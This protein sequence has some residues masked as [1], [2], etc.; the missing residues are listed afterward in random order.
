MATLN[1]H[2]ILKKNE[3][4]RLLSG[5]QW[6]FSNELHRIEGNPVSGDVVEILR[7]NGESLGIGFYNPNSLIAIRFLSSKVEE[8]NTEF[9]TKRISS[10]LAIRMKLFPTRD[11]FRVVHSESDFLPGLIIDKYGDFLS[12]QTNSTG[13]DI[14]LDIICEALKNIFS[15]KG[16]IERNES[17]LR[18]LENL[19]LRK[20]ILFGTAELTTVELNGVKFQIDILGGQKSGFY[21]DQ[22]ENRISLQTFAKDATVL[23]CF[24]NEGGFGLYAAM[25]GAKKVTG[26]DIS[27]DAVNRATAN[28]ALNGLKNIEF[29]TDDVF[30][31]LKKAVA[32]KL[33]YDIVI[34]D[35]PSFTK[36]KK[37]VS[38]AIRGYKEINTNGLQLVQSGGIFIS[39]SCSHHI[40]QNTFLDVLN[41]SAIK[42][43]K[44]IRLLKFSG[45]S[46][47]HP[48]LPSMP[49]TQY[50]KFALFNVD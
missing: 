10:A 4:R 17:Q 35:P 24:C 3:E 23:D 36:N 29:Q 7:G 42:A 38:A 21:L 28:A 37:T 44:K 26:V 22:R 33:R 6:I 40:D 25:F 15:P 30:E 49:E 39:A 31:F 9:F 11:T 32:E 2:V 5:H 19:E 13:M 48:T 34:L 47:D 45:A 50:L 43:R 14:R 46:A 20:N 16:I 12:V 27:G 1:K 41:D 18:A 8:I